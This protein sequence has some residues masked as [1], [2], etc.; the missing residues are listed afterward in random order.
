MTARDRTVLPDP[1]SPTTPR[2]FP[3]SSVK[4]TP[5]TARTLPRLVVK[6]TLRSSTSRSGPSVTA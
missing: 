1:D 5:C 3:C 4:E 6:E 2:V